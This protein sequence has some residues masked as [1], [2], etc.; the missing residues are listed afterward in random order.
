[1]QVM[2]FR[3]DRDG[4]DVLQTPGDWVEIGAFAG[5]GKLL[6]LEKVFVRGSGTFH[7]TVNSKPDTAALDPLAML[8]DRSPEHSERKIR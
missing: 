5:D 4:K 6:H 7:F 8:I 1:V 3:V 2:K